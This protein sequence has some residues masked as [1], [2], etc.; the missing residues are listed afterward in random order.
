MASRVNTL[1]AQHVL[2]NF[3]GF[4]LEQTDAL[5]AEFDTGEAGV[6]SCATHTIPSSCYTT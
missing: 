4:S 5:L 6:A 2:R 1:E 3:L